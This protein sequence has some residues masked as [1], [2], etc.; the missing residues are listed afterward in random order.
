MDIV[1]K[2]FYTSFMNINMQLFLSFYIPKKR[3]KLNSAKMH[4]FHISKI[5]PGIVWRIG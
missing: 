4:L 2:I 3:L 5:K 1:L